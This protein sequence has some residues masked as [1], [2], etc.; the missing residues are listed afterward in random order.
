MKA[1]TD[2]PCTNY[3][4]SGYYLNM[5]DYRKMTDNLLPNQCNKKCHPTQEDARIFQ[6][7]ISDNK[8][9][10]IYLCP[11]CNAWHISM[12]GLPPRL[13]DHLAAIIQDDSDH[14]KTFIQHTSRT[15]SIFDVYYGDD[16][17]KVIYSNISKKVKVIG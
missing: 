12:K 2:V 7:S 9:F 3:A 1:K 11:I 15:K 13:L 6:I 4:P 10:W 17:F 14:N 16:I 8:P 5:K